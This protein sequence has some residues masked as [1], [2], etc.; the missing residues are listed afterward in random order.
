MLRLF[1]LWTVIGEFKPA[2]DVTYS[3]SKDKDGQMLYRAEVKGVV[4]TY[5][6]KTLRVEPADGVTR[7][8]AIDFAGAVTGGWA[9][10]F[11]SEASALRSTSSFEVKADGKL[12]IMVCGLAPGGWEVWH[13][14]WLEDTSNGV[15]AKTGVLLFEG[16]EGSYFL[17]RSGG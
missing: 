3:L 17:R 7:I 8:E 11:H 6:L 15:D 1:L 2:P 12:K 4:L 10:L 9:I 14:G 16:T 13:N 5:D